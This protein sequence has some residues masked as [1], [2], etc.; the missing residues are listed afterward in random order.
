MSAKA[1]STAPAAS[2]PLA[3][4]AAWPNWEGEDIAQEALAAYACAGAAWSD[5]LGRLAAATDPFAVADAGARLMIDGLDIWSRA[6][7][8]RLQ[9]AAPLLSDA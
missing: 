7:A 5:Y 3:W 6:A 9:G 1:P 2:D 8:R 4:T